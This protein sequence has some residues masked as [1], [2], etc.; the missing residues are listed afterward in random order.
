M[1]EKE[2]SARQIALKK[3]LEESILTKIEKIKENIIVGK[4]AEKSSYFQMLVLIDEELDDVLLNWE[5]DSL[6][7]RP[8]FQDDLDDDDEA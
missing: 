7:S 1:K 3:A 6:S 5:Y 2:I 4:G 8:L